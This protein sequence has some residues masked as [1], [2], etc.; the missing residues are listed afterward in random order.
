VGIGTVNY[1]V[2]EEPDC[3]S[4]YCSHHVVG[5]LLAIARDQHNSWF[6]GRDTFHEIGRHQWKT[7]S[8]V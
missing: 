5:G 1:V 2:I 7:H 4:M 6:H 8:I 3:V